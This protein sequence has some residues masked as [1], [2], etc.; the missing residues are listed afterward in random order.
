MSIDGDVEGLRGF[1]T[2]RDRESD[3]DLGP[4]P[5]SDDPVIQLYTSGTTGKPKG[6]MLSH[7]NFL[8]TFRAMQRAQI[9]WNTYTPDD[10]SLVAM[11]VSHIGGTG[12]ALSA[13]LSGAKCVIAA[14]FDPNTVLDF[15]AHER[16][17]KLFLVPA[18]IQIVLRDPRARR[19]DYSCIQ[20]LVYGAS[21]IPLDLLREAVAVFGCGFAQAYGMTET[22]GI[23]TAL[24]PEDHDVAGNARM[25]SAGL[26]LPG[27]EMAVWDADG[28]ALPPGATGE[29]V[30]RWVGNMKGYWNMPEATAATITADGWLRTGD[31]GYLD[32]DGYVFIHD[33]VKDMIVSGGENV[34]PAEV[35]SAVFGHP[36]IAEVAVIGVPSE[37][38]GEE[39]KAIVVPKAGHTPDA[40]AIIR[41]ARTRIAAF[42]APKS[43]DFVEALPR[44][45]SGK[46]LHRQL[47]EPYWAGK[48]RRVN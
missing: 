21:P 40:D 18:A 15:V 16:I 2:W 29:L 44:N 11:P 39:V 33:R 45:P 30:V 46:I 34:Y 26:P 7:F 4:A 38:W 8:E 12:W 6:A 24:G 32:A 5:A 1:T 28:C 17:T 22:T 48:S 35:E 47:R 31:A 43:V 25:R 20:Y 19:T 14:E 37:M 3:H 27:V 41:F 13:I 36:D 10:I 9:P 42:K 23:V